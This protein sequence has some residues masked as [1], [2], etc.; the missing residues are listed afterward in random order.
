M[1]GKNLHRTERRMTTASSSFAQGIDVSKVQGTIDW[2]A[3]AQAGIAF[4]FIKATDGETYVDPQFAAN[5][6]GAGAAGLLRGAYHFFRAEDS[7]QSQ[8]DLFWQTV[9]GT[10]ELGLVVDV[11]ETMGV[12]NA[13]LITNLTQFLNEL[14]QVSGR[15]PMI[16]TYPTFWNGLGTTAFGA[17]PLWIAEYGVAAPTLPSGWSAWTYWQSSQSGT[18]GGITGAVDL[19]VFNGS[20]AELRA[21]SV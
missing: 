3:V 13:T 21:R 8:V 4:A 15:Q 7:P 20:E 5:W 16:Y 18:V 12:S 6:A 9:G 14:Q 1:I 10:G 19:D 17:Y 11:E 2:P